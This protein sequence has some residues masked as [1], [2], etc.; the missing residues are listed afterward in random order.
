MNKDQEFELAVNM[1]QKRINDG[2]V[3]TFDCLD[4]MIARVA[5]NWVGLWDEDDMRIELSSLVWELKPRE[6]RATLSGVPYVVVK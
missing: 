3:V 6:I 1:I 2:T 4:K 5:R